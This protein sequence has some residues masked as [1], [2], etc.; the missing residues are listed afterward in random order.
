[1]EYIVSPLT[2]LGN[3]GLEGVANFHVIHAQLAVAKLG[4][5]SVHLIQTKSCT[6][7]PVAAVSVLRRSGVTCGIVEGYSEVNA[8]RNKLYNF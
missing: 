4:M 2:R 8:S 6:F 1:M 5:K 3:Q 7:N